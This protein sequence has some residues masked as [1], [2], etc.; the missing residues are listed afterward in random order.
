MYI[1]QQLYSLKKVQIILINTS[2][3]DECYLYFCVHKSKGE[4][5]LAPTNFDAFSPQIPTI[6]LA[7]GNNVIT[8][9]SG[10]SEFPFEELVPEHRQS[11]F[12]MASHTIGDL[13]VTCFA[14]QAIFDDCIQFHQ[15]RNTIVVDFT[16]TY[17]LSFLEMVLNDSYNIALPEVAVSSHFGAIS[18]TAASSEDAGQ[19]FLKEVYTP[20]ELSAFL[21]GAKVLSQKIEV[22]RTYPSDLEYFFLKRT[23][24]RIFAA[25]LCL[26]FAILLINYFQLSALQAQ[27][28]MPDSEKNSLLLRIAKSKAQI[29]SLGVTSTGS[30]EGSTAFFADRIGVITPQGV[31]LTRLAYN[32]MEGQIEAGDITAIQSSV[33]EI[34]GTAH[35][36]SEVN[37]MLSNLKRE[38]WISNPI[39][40]DL[41]FV[42][43][44]SLYQFTIKAQ[45]K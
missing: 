37:Q 12:I 41:T 28:P 13:K 40:K 21:S 36:S 15:C 32:P 22:K 27:H 1:P 4:I 44:K 18:I 6:A 11:D 2:S 38:G 34:S 19:P 31:I 14:Q 3:A 25:G 16:S 20:S 7:Y 43:E 10:I 24:N 26:I 5:T 45:I 30:K 42:T 39:L 17:P 33:V 35:S 8:K 29:K 9:I 23:F